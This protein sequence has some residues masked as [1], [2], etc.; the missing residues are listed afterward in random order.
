MT[1]TLTVQ[2]G[3][4]GVLTLPLGEAN[5]NQLVRVTVETI[6]PKMTREEWQRFIEDTAG[7]IDDPTF[8]RYPQCPYEELG[9]C[10]RKNLGG[11]DEQ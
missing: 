5:A 7:K 10:V 11:E 3:A 4:N 9:F 1:R 8:K 6:R 2:V